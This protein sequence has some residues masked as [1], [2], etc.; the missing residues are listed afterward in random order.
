MECV[1]CGAETNANFI[2]ICKECEKQDDIK[3]ERKYIG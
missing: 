3:E 2:D 1:Y